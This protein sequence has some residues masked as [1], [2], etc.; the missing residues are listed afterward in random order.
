M[1]IFVCVFLAAVAFAAKPAQ[2]VVLKS[3]Q[4]EV[5]FDPLKGLPVDY[6]L[7]SNK[8]TL[9]G[10]AGSEVTVTIFR[11]SPRRYTNFAV[12]PEVIRSNKTRADFQFTVREKGAPMASFL[13]RYE[14]TGAEL[15]VSL[16][17]VL[18][19]QGFEL[20]DVG[21]PELA[22]VREEDGGAWLAH[23]DGGGTM[24]MLNKAA[25]GHLHGV[26]AKLP[27]VM[28]GSNRMLCVE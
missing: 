18:E 10:G 14:L 12:R 2:P 23:G 13:L 24:A 7:S 5:T 16:E 27:V 20:I 3:S 22:S 26:A 21:L 8:A 11:A 15:L 25:P 9:R 6:R 28:V 1:K 19:E 4:L 17:A